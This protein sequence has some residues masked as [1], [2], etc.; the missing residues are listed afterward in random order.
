MPPRSCAKLFYIRTGQGNRCRRTHRQ[1]L[2]ILELQ[3]QRYLP[4]RQRWSAHGEPGGKRTRRSC[5]GERTKRIRGWRGRPVDHKVLA[6][7]LAFLSRALWF[8]VS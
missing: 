4:W 3:M 7:L 6:G 2:G 5:R 8:V 1:W